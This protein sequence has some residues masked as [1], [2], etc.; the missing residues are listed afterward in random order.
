MCK[1]TEN[2]LLKAIED[3]R[4]LDDTSGALPRAPGWSQPAMLRQ[5][6][7]MTR[8]AP[9][10]LSLIIWCVCLLLCPAERQEEEWDRMSVLKTIDADDDAAAATAEPARAV[11]V[12]ACCAVADKRQPACLCRMEALPPAVHSSA[13]N[14]AERGLCLPCCAGC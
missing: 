8:M 7:V 4:F 12:R 6:C 2:A 5:V 13:H 11:G 14:T 10:G 3:L 1:E 9:S